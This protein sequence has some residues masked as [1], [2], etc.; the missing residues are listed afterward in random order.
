MSVSF[1]RGPCPLDGL[2]TSE[3]PGILGNSGSPELEA[4][5]SLDD[6]VGFLRL[7]REETRERG[8]KRVRALVCR[9]KEFLL[10]VERI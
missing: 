7:H 3:G 9:R 8:A 6:G 1:R 10:T 5:G 4:V 2:P